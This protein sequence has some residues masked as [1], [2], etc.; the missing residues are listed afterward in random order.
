MLKARRMV[1]F[2]V[3]AM[4]AKESTIQDTNPEP[5]RFDRLFGFFKGDDPC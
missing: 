4:T 1:E 2:E 5:D 3:K